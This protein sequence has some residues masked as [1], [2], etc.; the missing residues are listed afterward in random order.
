MPFQYKPLRPFCTGTA[1]LIWYAVPV[2]NVASLL[3]WNGVPKKIF[4]RIDLKL[5]PYQ[6]SFG[7]TVVQ[8][9]LLTGNDD[10]D[11]D[12]VSGEDSMH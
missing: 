12:G 2:Q 8:A 4:K 6:F 5:F 10:D 3:Y 9:E 11:D 7:I 1:Y